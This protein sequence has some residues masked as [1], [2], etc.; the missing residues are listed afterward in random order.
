MNQQGISQKQMA[1]ILGRSRCAVQRL[2][3]HHR[4]NGDVSYLSA[5]VDPSIPQLPLDRFGNLYAT[6]SGTGHGLGVVDLGTNVTDRLGI[7][8]LHDGV[9]RMKRCWPNV[10]VLW[11]YNSTRLTEI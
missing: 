8:G 2:L 11:Y 7:A 9:A 10:T 4:G 5:L 6:V 3:D 1:A